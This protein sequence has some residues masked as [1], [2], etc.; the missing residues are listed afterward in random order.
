M[1]AGKE[2]RRCI[3]SRMAEYI[4]LSLN[5]SLIEERAGSRSGQVSRSWA[6]QELRHFQM[7]VWSMDGFAASAQCFCG[8]S[9]DEDGRQIGNASELDLRLRGS[10]GAT[11]APL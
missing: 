5:L 1:P 4:D 11:P 8:G 7:W 2:P 9:L 10:P 6:R 3:L